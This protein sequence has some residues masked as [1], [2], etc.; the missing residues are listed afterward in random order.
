MPSDHFRFKQF[1][2]RQ[3]RC[4]MKVSTDGV[5]L[6]AWACTAPAGRILDVGTGTGLLALIAAQRIPEAW[7]DAVEVDAQAAGQARENVAS[8]PWPGRIGIHKADIRQW[9]SGE[10]YDLVLCNPPFHKG[11]RPSVNERMAKAKHEGTLGLLELLAAIERL[12]TLNGRAAMI[13]PFDR[14]EELAAMAGAR[15]F[16]VARLCTVQHLAGKSPKR[17][18]V[19]LRHGPACA[20]IQETLVVQLPDGAFSPEYRALLADLELHF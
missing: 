14:L 5:L 20:A 12:I 17:A 3:D 18:L 10:R 13:L 16:S 19:E 1:T 8:S 7:I 15:G 2:V 4:A 6:G 9:A 11:H